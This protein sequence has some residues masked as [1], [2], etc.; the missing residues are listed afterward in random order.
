MITM[1]QE[2][3]KLLNRIV[4]GAEYLAN[5]LIKPRDF[6]KGMLLYDSLC[7]KLEELKRGA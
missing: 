3:Q 2:Y 4:K 7:K 1:E 6:E 5:P